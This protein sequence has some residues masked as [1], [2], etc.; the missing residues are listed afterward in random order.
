MSSGIGRP[1]MQR[2]RLFTFCAVALLRVAYP[3]PEQDRMQEAVVEM[4]FPLR[5]K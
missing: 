5:A 1:R 4:Q 2:G 3:P